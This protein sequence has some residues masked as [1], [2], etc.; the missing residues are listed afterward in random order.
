MLDS[1]ST[2]TL[3]NETFLNPNWTFFEAQKSV[4]KIQLYFSYRFLELEYA[5]NLDSGGEASLRLSWLQSKS[6]HRRCMVV[7]IDFFLSE[8]FIRLVGGGI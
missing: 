1:L 6:F 7:S 5:A 3:K 8:G 4:R 2:E